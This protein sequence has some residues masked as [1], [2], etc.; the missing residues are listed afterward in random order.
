[1]AQQFLRTNSLLMKKI[2][3]LTQIKDK[4]QDYNIISIYILIKEQVK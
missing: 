3:D 2:K 1:M 4:H